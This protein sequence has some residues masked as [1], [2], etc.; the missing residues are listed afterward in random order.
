MPSDVST[1][2]SDQHLGGVVDELK[3]ELEA[4]SRELAE[5]RQ[6]QAAT[7]GIL[8]AIS[9]SSTDLDGIF[10][11]M[12]ASAARLCDSYDAGIARVDGNVLRNV[13][14]G[15]PITP[16]VPVGAAIPIGRGTVMGRAILDR[17]AIQV[18]DAQAEG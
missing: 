9:T 5:A 12:A 11:A 15:G 7:A 8:R 6:Q 10:T 14:H 16:V 18:D 17:Q 1:A 2:G 13:A 3:R 4:K